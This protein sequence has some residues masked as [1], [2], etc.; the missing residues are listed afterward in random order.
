M[1]NRESSFLFYEE[2]SYECFWIRK[3]DIHIIKPEV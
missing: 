1:K 2:M 3:K